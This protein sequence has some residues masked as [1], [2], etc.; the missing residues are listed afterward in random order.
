[1]SEAARAEEGLYLVDV[2]MTFASRGKKK[3]V[4]TN[5]EQV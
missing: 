1:M 3:K 5:I 4:V 2:D